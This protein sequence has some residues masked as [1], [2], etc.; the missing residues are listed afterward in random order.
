[1][2]QINTYFPVTYL[3]ALAQQICDTKKGFFTPTA[4]Y[5][6][7]CILSGVSFVENTF[8]E[9][10][11]KLSYTYFFGALPWMFEAAAC[12]IFFLSF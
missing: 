4:S 8:A 2:S 11:T 3:H 5:T 10:K 6:D 1:M 9:D 7:G 12:F